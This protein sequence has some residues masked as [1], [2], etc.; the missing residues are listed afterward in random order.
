MEAHRFGGT[1]GMPR[2]RDEEAAASSRRLV[3]DVAGSDPFSHVFA[4]LDA[5]G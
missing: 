2:N 4:V 1:A 5:L 3:I